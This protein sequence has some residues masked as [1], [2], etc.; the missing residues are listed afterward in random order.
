MGLGATASGSTGGH[1]ASTDL[2]RRPSGSHR[3]AGRRR[4]AG[5][6]SAGDRPAPSSAVGWPRWILGA[7]GRVSLRHAGSQAMA[8]KRGARISRVG[9]RGFGSWGSGAGLRRARRAPGGG[10]R[11]VRVDSDSRGDGRPAVDRRGERAKAG[12]GGRRTRWATCPLR[13]AR[14]PAGHRVGGVR[15]RVERR[16]RGFPSP[17][18]RRA[19]RDSCFNWARCRRDA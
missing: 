3:S 13:P 19:R 17:P 2:S 7:A 4:R 10:A 14:R 8:K 16:G 11:P 12:A 9:R 18:G 6:T 1:V 15:G 5:R